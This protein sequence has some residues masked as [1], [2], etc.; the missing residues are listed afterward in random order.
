MGQPD[1]VPHAGFEYAYRAQ[2]ERKTGGGFAS[3]IYDAAKYWP[4]YD[5]SKPLGGGRP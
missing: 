3:W 2:P 5:S 4:I 1:A